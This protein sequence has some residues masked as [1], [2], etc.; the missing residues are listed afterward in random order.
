MKPQ[1]V[2]RSGGMRVERWGHSLGDEGAGYGMR[3]NWRVHQGEDSDWIVK[4]LKNNN[5]KKKKKGE[6]RGKVRKCWRSQ[7][8]EK[9]DII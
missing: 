9:R 1:V 5:L 4:K 8:T 2:G 6:K 3:N 7:R